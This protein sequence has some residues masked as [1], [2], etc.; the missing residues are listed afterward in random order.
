MKK[1]ITLLGLMGAYQIC[2][3]QNTFPTT[4]GTNVGIGTV[5]P[6]VPLEVFRDYGTAGSGN[7][8]R[9]GGKNAWE[10]YTWEG[11]QLGFTQFRSIYEGN[12]LWGLG[13]RTGWSDGVGNETIRFSGSGQVGIGTSSPKAKLHTYG[14]SIF[15]TNRTGVGSSSSV[16]NVGADE[17]IN[18]A[19]SSDYPNGDYHKIGKWTTNNT[20]ALQ[21]I[22]VGA[23]HVNNVAHLFKTSYDDSALSINA[24]GN[25]GIGTS[26]PSS[27]LDVLGDIRIGQPTAYSSFLLSN[28]SNAISGYNQTSFLISPTVPGSGIAR[29]AFRFKSNSSGNGHNIMDVLVDGNVGIG[30]LSPQEKLEVNGK[31]RAKEIK[32]ETANWPDYVFSSSYKLPDLQATEQFIKENKHLPEIPSAAEVEKDGL[33]LGEMNAKLLKKIEELTLHL[34]A[35]E[36]RL[37]SMHSYFKNEN[38]DLKKAITKLKETKNQ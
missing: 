38:E 35:Q 13:I 37:E 34:I 23:D 31:I 15:G 18:F 27:K 10:Y 4:V 33:S 20:Y 29:S 2:A 6:A 24:A 1:I 26:L 14:Q 12:S 22:S 5:S 9:L 36:K 11:M 19:F 32:V 28:E 3:A 30:M 17:F 16:I 7:L 8:L 21:Y 25:V